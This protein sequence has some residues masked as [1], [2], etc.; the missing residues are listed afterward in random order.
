VASTVG[1]IGGT[2][3][4]GK[5]L[6][7][8]FAKAGREVFVGSRDAARGEAAAKE[9]SELTGTRLRGGLNA[10]AAK[11]AD[12]VVA[13]VPYDGMTETLAG[14]ADTIGDK[15]LVS[16]V[17]PLS[18]SRAGIRLLPVQDGSAAAEAQLVVPQARVVGAFQNL[19]ASHLIALDHAV[20]GD[21]IVCS[22]HLEATREVI[23]LAETIPGVRGI[24]GGSLANAGLVEGMTALLINLNRL[25]KAETQLRIVGL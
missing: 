11:A 17:V 10:A 8:R 18:F 12:I 13:A 5:G 4:E 9:L 16:A 7:A 15:I 3:P 23:E 1:I 20:E 6:A 22:D 21:V 19:S 24:N 14:L 25:H 2:G